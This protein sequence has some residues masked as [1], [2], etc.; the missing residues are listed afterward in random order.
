MFDSEDGCPRICVV[1]WYN[2]RTGTIK[3][4]KKSHKQFARYDTR[5][6]ISIFHSYCLLICIFK[7][8]NS[9]R[10]KKKKK[11]EEKFFRMTWNFLN[12]PYPCILLITLSSA[13]GRI[14]KNAPLS[15]HDVF[16]CNYMVALK[17]FAKKRG[18]RKK[19]VVNN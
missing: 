16:T 7:P 8:G 12:Y 1:D 10:K 14:K 18:R 15:T 13:H 6:N 11:K 17:I 4:S 19:K 3:L 9:L 5:K 2:D